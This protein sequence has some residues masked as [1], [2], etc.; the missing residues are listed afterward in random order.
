MADTV[1]GTFERFDVF[2][3]I[4]P[5]RLP[6]QSLFAQQYVAL[7]MMLYKLRDML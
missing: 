4:K 5:V 3:N 6:G 7:G 2:A 1:A